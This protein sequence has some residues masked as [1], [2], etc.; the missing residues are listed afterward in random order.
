MNSEGKRIQLLVWGLV[1][2][3]FV[4]GLGTISII[5]WTLSTMRAERVRLVIEEQQLFQVSE[6]ISRL[7]LG[8]RQEIESILLE[9]TTPTGEGQ[10]ISSLQQV[11]QEQSA[12]TPDE[13]FKLALYKLGDAAKELEQLWNKASLWK[14][15]FVVTFEDLT[16]QHT[17]G[18]VRS[19]LHT[20]GAEVATLEGR[21]RLK[22]AIQL[23]RWQA[24]K[25]GKAAGIAKDILSGQMKQ[26][27][28]ALREIRSEIGDVA[29]LVEVLAGEQQPD[30]LTNIK[31]NTLKPSINRLSR[32][33]HALEDD[34]TL[35]TQ[36]STESIEALNVALFGKG[37][38]IDE[39]H[40][41]IRVGEG[42]LYVL[43][44][45]VLRLR[46]ERKQLG[47]ELDK[48][49]KQ[50]EGIQNEFSRLTQARAKTL[51][52]GVEKRLTDVLDNLLVMGGLSF[53]GFFVLAWLIS[54]GIRRQVSAIEETRAIADESN[55]MTQRV[56]AE[57]QVAAEA[58]RKAQDNL[59]SIFENAVEGIYQSTPDGRFMS[60]NPAMARMYG[61]ETPEEVIEDVTDIEHQVYVNAQDRETFARLMNEQ[62]HV[63][64]FEYQ[65]KRRDGSV[66]WTSENAHEIRDADDT[67]LYYEGMVQDISERKHA[68]EELR[69][70]SDAA[71]QAN[72][73]KSDFLASMSHELRTP[74]NGILGYAQIL[75]RDPELSEKQKSGVDVIQRSGD[76]L[77]N[78][79]NDILDL[80]KIEA[81]KLELQLTE[82]HLPDFL[83]QIANIIRVRAE[84]AELS[85]EYES[86]SDIPTGVRGDE[87]RLRQVLLN[88]L[89]NA[90]KF[91]EKG[92][93]VLKVG[94]DN[95]S[96]GSQLLR[97]QVEDTGRGIPQ[98]QLREIF[99]PFQQVSDHSRPVE[100]TG[101]GLS[102]TKKLV[103]LMGG[104]LGVTSVPEQGS[105]FWFT[106]D[107]PA[108]DVEQVATRPVER[109]ITG[110]KGERKRILIADDKEANRGIIVNLLEPM[111]FEVLEAVNGEDGLNKATEHPPDLI[112][113]DLVMPVMDG[114]E[115]TR[116]IRQ[117][118]ALKDTLIIA[119]SASVFEFNQKDS[120]A[121]GC[122][123]FLTKPVRADH[124]F[125]KL[126]THLGVEW[127]YESELSQEETVTT[128]SSTLVAPPAEEMKT[129]VDL[130][131]KGKINDIRQRIAEI[132]RMGEEY[133]PFAAE[134][135][136]LAK[137]FDMDQLT[138]FL[139]PFL[140]KT[141]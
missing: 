4:V 93:V 15:Q 84:Q 8:S 44:H 137:S 45:D 23:R 122:N 57:Q 24:A 29:R 17:L 111:G 35:P 5:G 31:D 77:L 48:V 127:V 67:L 90:V 105:T 133:R 58:L 126:H 7:A 54:R 130:A 22:D 100:G 125:E 18:K 13:R 39:A 121:A 119:S 20:L 73:A 103:G 62:G 50:I 3:A 136:R 19:L 128:R 59:H 27:T 99:Q 9:E 140:E 83:Q 80:S 21:R 14:T 2:V 81:Q 85:F 33:L 56:L 25:G 1:A 79:I 16:H 10:I 115:A 68:Q 131:E 95:S 53:A 124:L 63:E 64:D 40:Q 109:M 114:I 61:Y 74:L 30:N 52:S 108:V 70:A 32:S 55:R 36:L 76:H 12:S 69:R 92:G 129:L 82:F 101:L 71:D 123:D 97:F 96:D 51:T 141:E 43:R 91:T 139:N 118:P 134:L 106:V 94:Y 42:G 26:Q 66:F 104:E 98:D 117:V 113:M 120:L 49:F 116:R 132:E 38:L 6:E 138:E 110:Y 89:G 86:V 65:I 135:N 47:S 34:E 112:L 28:Q 72:K 11:I 41:T 87:K 60:V 46:E 78:L 37:Y 107:L 75:K 102:I 88:L